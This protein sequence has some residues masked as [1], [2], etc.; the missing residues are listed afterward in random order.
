MSSLPPDIVGLPPVAS[1]S[2]QTDDR[3]E[4]A[5][6]SRTRL[7]SPQRPISIA[8]SQDD[9]HT[10]KTWAKTVDDPWLPLILTLDGGGIRGYSSLL[11]LQRLMHEVA[12][13]ENSL[14]QD[15]CRVSERLGSN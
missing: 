9:V 7:N 10:G 3:I 8:S 1:S 6:Q 15:E 2:T 14:E 4:P 11:I 12:L 13:C 5:S